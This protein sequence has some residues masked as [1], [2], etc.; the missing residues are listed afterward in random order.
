MKLKEPIEL[1]KLTKNQT[2]EYIDKLHAI[3]LKYQI[4]IDIAVSKNEKI[5]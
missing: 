5:E 4:I 1:S 3:L 2:Y